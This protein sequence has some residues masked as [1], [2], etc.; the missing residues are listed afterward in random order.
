MDDLPGFIRKY[1]SE[2]SFLPSS[3]YEV[4]LFTSIMTKGIHDA[5]S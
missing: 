3:E 2:F 4:G 5:I 1:E